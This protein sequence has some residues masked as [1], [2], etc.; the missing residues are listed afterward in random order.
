MK[1]NLKNPLVFFDLETTG[2]VISRDKIIEIS[3]LKVS[4]DNSEVSRTQRINPEMP[5]PE[6]STMIHGI[7]DQD[8]GNSPTFKQI[9][10][11]IAQFLEG[12]DLGGFSIIKFDVPMLVEE[13]LRVDL[14]FNV[15]TRKLV[16]AQKIFFLMEKRNLTAA[17]KFYCGKDLTQ[18]HSAEADTL[19]SFEVL[20]A[21]ISRYAGAEVHD[22]QGKLIGQIDNSIES[23]NGITYSKIVDFAGRMA[24]GHQNQ[25]IFNFGKHRG[26]SV[27]DVLKEEPQYYDWIMNGD[28]PLDTKRRLTEIKL[29][30]FGK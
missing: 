9:A 19:A 30:G 25:V 26:K 21:Q 28:F 22:L 6:E 16:D 2:T 7:T 3:M 14:E 13:F 8:V 23:L 27:T 29:Q 1:L 18:A 20:K 24:Y 17:Y 4:P 15:R 11:S 10:K 12:C 5:I